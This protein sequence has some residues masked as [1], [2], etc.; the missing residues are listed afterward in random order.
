MALR[1]VIPSVRRALPTASFSPPGGFFD[2]FC[3]YA[4]FIKKKKQ[5]KAF[6]AA[7]LCPGKGVAK[8]GAYAI[9]EQLVEDVPARGEPGQ[10]LAP[11]SR[12]VNT[13]SLGHTI[14]GMS[15]PYATAFQA[16]G[17]CLGQ[18]FAKYGAYAIG[19]NLLWMFLQGARRPPFPL[20]VS[21]TP[22]ATLFP[23]CRALMQQAN[24]QTKHFA[25]ITI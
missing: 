4:K 23:Q 15:H 13:T 18:G 19:N 7:V 14:F 10:G 9:R 12:P 22:G 25:T 5:I 1:A 20:P 24:R 17:F 16:A 8:Y 6:Q 21:T 3:S 11:L 2:K